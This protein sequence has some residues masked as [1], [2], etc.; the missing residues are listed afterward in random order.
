MGIYESRM[1]GVIT[2]EPSL[3][4]LTRKQLWTEMHVYTDV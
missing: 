3:K 4:S 2:T 1:T